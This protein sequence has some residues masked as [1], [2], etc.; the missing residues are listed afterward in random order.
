MVSIAQSAASLQTIQATSLLQYAETVFGWNPME[1]PS[2]AIEQTTLLH[3]HISTR[4]RVDSKK[5]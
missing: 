5:S 1:S 2:S 4:R 3:L